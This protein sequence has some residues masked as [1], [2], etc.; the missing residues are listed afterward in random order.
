MEELL[1]V[2]IQFVIEFIVD[3]VANIPFDW[4]SRNRTTPER[5]SVVGECV[6]WP[7]LGAA[8]A[9]ASLLIFPRTM[10]GLPTLRIVNAALAPFAS[11]FLSF[12]IAQR[13]AQNNPNLIPRNHFWRAF[14][15]TTGLVIIRFAYA[16]RS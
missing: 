7:L 4:P 2:V 13:R 11:A 10:I 9:G 8:L 15:F 1:V 14:W 12:L 16:A 3:V 5:E 6:L